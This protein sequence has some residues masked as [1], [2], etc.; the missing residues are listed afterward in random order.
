M[1]ALRSLAVFLLLLNALIAR[2]VDP[3][4]VEAF[5]SLPDLQGAQLSPDGKKVAALL[6]KGPDTVLVVQMSG[7]KDVFILAKTDNKLLAVN[8]FRW[9]NDERIVV[10]LRYPSRRLGIASM[11]SR[12][13]SFRYDGS[14]A[15]NLMEPNPDRDRWIPQFQDRVIDWLPEDPEHILVAADFAAP[16]VLGTWRI[17]VETGRR[18]RVRNRQEEN[19]IRWI[20]DR[21][22]RL[23]VGVKFKDAH[24]WIMICDPEE[25]AWVTAWEY[26][27]FSSDAV[28]PIGFG[29]DPNILYVA[30]DHEGRGAIFTVDLRDPE[31]RLALKYADPNNDV[32]DELVYSEKV[33][34]YIGVV[35]QDGNSSY[36]FW[37]PEYQGLA[38]G[39]DRALPETRNVIVGFSADESRYLVF[40]SGNRRPGVYYLGD[41]P[42][43]TLTELGSAY[44]QLKP[45]MLAGKQT[46]KY[47]ARDGLEIQAYLT[48][49]LGREPRNLPMVVFPHG[50]PIARDGTD[51]DYWT[52]FFANRGY[53]V[54]QMDFR[55]SAGF[56]RDF[57]RAGLKQWGLR[58]QDDI[59]DGVQT[60]IDAGIADKSRI[61]IVGASY[62]GYAA[63]MGA[64]R[65]PDLYQCAISFAGV[66]DLPELLASQRWYT[67]AKVSEMQI[68]NARE[69]R[70]QLLATSPR[71]LAD[72]IKIPVLL[73]HGA[74]DRSVPVEHSEMM[75]AALTRAGKA[76]RFIRQEDGD[77]FL[78]NYENRLQLFQEMEKFLAQHL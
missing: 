32:S 71:L 7:S 16:L 12:L 74:K 78:S 31:R 9:A 35:A 48:V 54:L 59:S 66:S 68:G 33:G 76:H 13:V 75:D 51:F 15:V 22:H 27:S 24:Y 58:M 55:G 65:T 20:T 39:I 60:M 42:S 56:G 57:M 41:R 14:K 45:E 30:A 25:K 23:R 50:G 49:P 69:D 70:E 61:C 64:A 29:N 63:L 17:N 10:S 1:V 67:I 72:K 52:E 62:G 44:P 26:S 53:A 47:K 21:Q 43:K 11:E 38:A 46:L 4:P 18:M 28:E 3:L 8:W 34:D 36:V 19:V 6:N 2:A 5:A 73:V 77:H 37:R 40:A